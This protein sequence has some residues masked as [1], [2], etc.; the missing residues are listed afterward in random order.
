MIESGL[1]IHKY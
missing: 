1:I